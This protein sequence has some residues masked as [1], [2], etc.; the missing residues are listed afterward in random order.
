M[1]ESMPDRILHAIA[2]ARE[3]Y[4]RF[5]VLA[6][7]TRSGKTPALKAVSSATS[8]PMIN[9]NLELSRQIRDRARIWRDHG[10]ADAH[11]TTRA[12]LRGADGAPDIR[13]VQPCASGVAWDACSGSRKVR[14]A[15]PESTAS[16]IRTPRLITATSLFAARNWRRRRCAGAPSSST[17]SE[18]QR[19]VRQRLVGDG[20]QR[21]PQDI[22][23]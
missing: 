17:H 7:P 14:N 23:R 20:A 5:V 11:T 16:C 19:V 9:V 8:A 6:G 3:C 2:Q 10:N 22:T 4:D 1:M 12:A 15:L 18:L 21:M 13:P